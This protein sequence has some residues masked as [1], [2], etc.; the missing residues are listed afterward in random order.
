ME[1]LLR[2][3]PRLK[4]FGDLWSSRL[5]IERDGYMDMG[6]IE[7][8]NVK[9]FGAVGDG[10]TDDTNAIIR[11]LEV[12]NGVSSGTWETTGAG[13]SALPRRRVSTYLPPGKYRVTR[14]IPINFDGITIIGFANPA[15]GCGT[16]GEYTAFIIAD[17]DAAG[18]K[19]NADYHID[20]FATKNI[21]IGKTGTYTHDGHAIWVSGENW[22]CGF[23]SF[24]DMVPHFFCNTQLYLGFRQVSKQRPNRPHQVI[25]V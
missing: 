15:T 8:I 6:T 3:Y 2:Y 4:S 18:I 7:I 17:H 1:C 11:T 16:W 25:F 22:S 9:D 19:L 12:A 21:S 10:I 5:N 24:F 13:F 20:Y 14:T 23:C